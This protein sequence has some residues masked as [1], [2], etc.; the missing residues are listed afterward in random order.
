MILR[1]RS[2]LAIAPFVSRNLWGDPTTLDPQIAMRPVHLKRPVDAT[3]TAKPRAFQGIPGI[4]CARNGV[5]WATWYAGGPGEGPLNFVLLAR[6]GDNGN[7]WNVEWVIDPPTPVRAFDPCL[8]MDPQGRLWL[9][10]SQ[11]AGLWD[12]RGGVWAAVT[13]TPHQSAAVWSEPRLLANGVMMNKP[14]VASNGHWLLPIGGWRFKPPVIREPLEKV[15]FPNAKEAAQLLAHDVGEADGSAVFVSSDEGR[16][17][18]LLGQARVPDT[19]HDEHMV[20][21][22]RDGSYWMLVRTTYGIGQ[23]HSSDGGTTWTQ[24]GPSKI[25]HP[26]TRFCIRRLRSGKLL[27]VRND[28]PDGK[29]RSHLTAFLSDDEGAHWTGG[30][31][32]DER[33]GVSYP[34]F[35]EREDGAICIIYD[36]DRQGAGEIL[37]AIV[38]EEDIA[39]GRLH[40]SSRLRVLVDRGGNL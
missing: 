40:P 22:H 14:T 5:L 36:R 23:S 21:E 26:V 38:R 30:L 1:R 20:V 3:Y 25:P 27:L 15:Q 7:T 29:T 24:G 35:A 8:W 33:R 12:G 13:D 39:T 9:F 18:R 6:S 19:Q 31:L 16:S 37:M 11:S 2:F 4:E 32:L 17:F 34:D 10:W 28:P